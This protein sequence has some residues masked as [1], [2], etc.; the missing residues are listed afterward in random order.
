MNELFSVLELRPMDAQILIG[1]TGSGER[2]R[3]SGLH[4]NLKAN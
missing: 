2:D 1:E 3:C 4:P